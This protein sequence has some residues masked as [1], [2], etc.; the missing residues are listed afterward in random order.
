MRYGPRTPLG[1]SLWETTQ[2]VTRAFDRELAVHGVNRPI[3]FVFLNIDEGVHTTQRDL[4]RAIGIS[5][6]TLSHHLG[7]LEERGLIR[8]ERDARDRRSQRIAFTDEGRA[9]F[10]DMKRAA[11]GFDRELRAALGP[12]R[13]ADLQAALSTLATTFDTGEPVAPNLG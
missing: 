10:E 11:F 9:A 5:D 3:W 1:M 4:A 6:A 12:E 2:I 13:T 7:N 8:R